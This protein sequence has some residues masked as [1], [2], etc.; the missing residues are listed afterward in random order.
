MPSRPFIDRRL[1]LTVLFKNEVFVTENRIKDDLN[2]VLDDLGYDV[3]ITNVKYIENP[4][5]IKII[6]SESSLKPGSINTIAGRFRTAFEEVGGR[7]QTMNV[8]STALSPGGK[9]RNAM[10]L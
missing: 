5:Q 3:Y 2:N 1:G 4:P 9:V 6:F 8:T 10:P 7:V